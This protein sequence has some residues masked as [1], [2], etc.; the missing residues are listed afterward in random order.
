MALGEWVDTQQ[1]LYGNVNLKEERKN[2]LNKIGLQWSIRR[3]A[4]NTMCDTLCDYATERN[5]A[6]PDNHWDG[7][8]P[9]KYNTSGDSPKALGMWVDTQKKAYRKYKLNKERKDRLDEIGL[10][11]NVVPM[12][13]P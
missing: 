10:R 2:R 3:T 13:R 4:W 7:T 11:W 6:D 12:F 1:V 5:A 9:S 8:V